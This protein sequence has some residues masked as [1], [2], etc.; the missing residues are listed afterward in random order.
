MMKVG[1]VQTYLER[2]D[3]KKDNVSYPHVVS[4]ITYI[5]KEGR[6]LQIITKVLLQAV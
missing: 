2:L 5:K 3:G 4:P 6:S 1:G